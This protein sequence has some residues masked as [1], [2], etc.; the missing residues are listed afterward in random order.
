MTKYIHHVCIDHCPDYDE[1]SKTS[2]HTE[3]G[4]QC[5]ICRF[6]EQEKKNLLISKKEYETT[7]KVLEILR[8][9]PEM[10]NG[11]KELFNQAH[12]SVSLWME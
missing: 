2:S 1:C 10:N 3:N 7:L 4:K 11:D 5:N 12:H 6:N 8:D 9:R